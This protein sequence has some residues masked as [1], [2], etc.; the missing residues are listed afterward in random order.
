MTKQTKDCNTQL[1]QDITIPLTYPTSKE[2]YIDSDENSKDKTPLRDDE[3][4]NNI[5]SSNNIISQFES[6]ESSSS[7]D[8]G[9]E[10]PS[11]EPYEKKYIKLAT[12]N[13]LDFLQT[14]DESDAIYSDGVLS[15]IHKAANLTFVFCL[16]SSIF[17]AFFSQLE[18][19]LGF[20]FINFSWTRLY[21]LF[22]FFWV[23]YLYRLNSSPL[24]LKGTISA[25]R[26]IAMGIAVIQSIYQLLIRITSNS[27]A[28]LVNRNPLLYA[29]SVISVPFLVFLEGVLS[30][31]Q[32][33][34][35]RKQA[36]LEE[37]RKNSQSSV[38]KAIDR[39]GERKGL[40][41]RTIS[42]QLRQTTDMATDTLKQ[43]YP[44]HLLS[45]P[46]EHLSACS[47][48]FPTASVNAIHVILKD[49][50][51]ISTHLGT[52]SLLLFSEHN[53][54]TS[55]VRKEFDIGEVI[56]HVGDVLAGDACNAKIELVIYHEEYSL[57]H[58]NVIG[59][60]AAFRHSLLD[61][62]N[63]SHI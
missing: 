47:I 50:N 62:S 37:E 22:A 39:F 52:L 23:Y 53:Q 61:V 30:A 33:E 15:I 18:S 19:S 2:T 59:D 10:T 35:F 6:S 42:N 40:Y 3:E 54:E 28:D 14:S 46:H 58:L 7:E 49:I 26:K 25:A 34:N 29:G 5:L 38:Y 48:S 41:L 8:E 51:Y 27:E 1:L 56:Q 32:R 12:I 43:L 36:L 24:L 45:K 16:V 17:A 44:S 21:T 60:E 11:K 63:Y 13:A 57:N 20:W 55:S 4:I 9:Y 31:Y